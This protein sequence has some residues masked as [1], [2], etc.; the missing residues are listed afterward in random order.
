MT[1]QNAISVMLVFDHKS[2]LSGLEQMVAG[3][4]Q[5]MEL[6]AST[7]D[8]GSR[9]LANTLCPDVIVLDAD[10]RLD[11]GSPVDYLP[12]LL[13]NGVSRAMLF[14]GS[15]EQ[16]L[17]GRA[18]RSSTRGVVGK[19]TPVEQLVDTIDRVHQG[20][21]SLEQALLDSMLCALNRPEPAPDPRRKTHRQADR[22]GTQ[23]HRHDVGRK[24]RAEQGHRP[25]RLYFRA[26][27][28]QPPDLD[29]QQARRHQPAGTVCVRHPQP[30][31]R[32]PGN[33]MTGQ[34]SREQFKKTE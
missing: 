17:L 23:D 4:A 15:Q 1:I 21:L 34:M 25:A 33:G 27:L 9:L 5:A 3:A 19:D 18:V 32:K 16:E 6:V 12:E 29:L 31:G 20:E 26:D 22:Q 2:L 13:G 10:L 24:W 14:S 8:M 7:T 11:G 30:A 28:A